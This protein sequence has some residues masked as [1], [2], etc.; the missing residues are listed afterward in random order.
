MPV[1]VIRMERWAIDRLVW[2]HHHIL[3]PVALS[4]CRNR[5]FYP[6][7]AARSAQHLQLTI[8]NAVD[9]LMGART[10]GQ[11]MTS[12]LAPQGPMGAN[13][14]HS[15]AQKP[16]IGQAQ[17]VQLVEQY[18]NDYAMSCQFFPYFSRVPTQFVSLAY[19]NANVDVPIEQQ[20]E[21]TQLLEQLHRQCVEMECRLLVPPVVAF[22]LK[23]VDESF[24]KRVV[25][26]VS[27]LF[28]LP[29]WYA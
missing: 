26:I 12:S 2:V 15:F 9:G 10:P 4:K 24:L 8:P 27:F 7:L 28:L 16:S 11:Q 20:V 25:T 21:Y 17:A 14:M 29:C 23:D 1:M 13:T 19:P 3:V 18:K 22:I 5:T 6:L